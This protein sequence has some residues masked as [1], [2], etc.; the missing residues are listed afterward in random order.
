MRILILLSLIYLTEGIQEHG[1]LGFQRKLHQMDVENPST[2]PDVRP[3]IKEEEVTKKP[4]EIKKRDP[5]SGPLSFYDGQF[6]AMRVDKPIIVSVF[7][8]DG[9][10]AAK[11]VLNKEATSVKGSIIKAEEKY[12]VNLDWKGADISDNGLILE[13]IFLKMEFL[14]DKKEYR[15][16]GMDAESVRIGSE[17]IVYNPLAVKSNNG[18]GIKAPVGT[19]FCCSNPGMF[20][21]SN[22][23]AEANSSKYKVGITLP[24]VQLQV[25]KLIKSGFGPEW[26]CANLLS[27]GLWVTLLITLG[28][29]LV[30][31]WGFSMLA[32]INTMD[33]FD[34]PKGKPLI[35]NTFD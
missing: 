8:R 15:L 32:G 18:Y 29:T 13:N 19:S 7:A 27:I 2:V 6:F 14:K 3:E 4:E 33:K 25:F 10:N 16:S 17:E 20:P 23:S 5:E 31:Y 9:K 26:N 12:L 21:P 1:N 11:F 34:D 22:K 35:I 30:C 28:F 24:G